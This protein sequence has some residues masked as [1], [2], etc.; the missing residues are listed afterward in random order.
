M[1]ECALGRYRPRGSPSNRKERHRTT[2]YSQCATLRNTFLG[3]KGRYGGGA[4]G[5]AWAKN[6]KSPGFHS[7]ASSKGGGGGR[8][9]D[10]AVIYLI[11]QQPNQTKRDILMT[12]EPQNLFSALSFILSSFSYQL[13]QSFANVIL[14]KKLQRF[15]LCVRHPTP[16]HPFPNEASLP[17]L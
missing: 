5:T 4:D 6:G 12:A 2:K 1:V 3:V 10:E 13:Q 17:E 9:G 11:V 8:R 15:P 7:I 16:Q 14:Y